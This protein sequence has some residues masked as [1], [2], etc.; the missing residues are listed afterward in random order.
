MV[1]LKL[2]RVLEVLYDLIQNELHVVI[3]KVDFRFIH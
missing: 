2:L 3:Q 1:V